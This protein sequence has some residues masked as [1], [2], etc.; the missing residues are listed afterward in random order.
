MIEDHS[1]GP[2]SS[3]H[4]TR[5]RVLFYAF[6]GIGAVAGLLLLLNFEIAYQGKHDWEAY[7]RKALA[8]G[9][10]LD[11]SAFIPPPVPDGQN[12]ACTPS[13][14]PLFDFLPGTQQVR[15][16]NA[17]HFMDRLDA[18]F[19]E[20]A[21][22]RG[23]DPLM[24]DA[25]GWGDYAKAQ[26]YDLV[27]FLGKRGSAL[28][29][30][31]GRMSPEMLKR[32]GLVSNPAPVPAPPA[33]ETPATPTNETEAAEVALGLLK[34]V[35]E[36]LFEELRQAQKRPFCRFNIAYDYDPAYAILLPHVPILRSVCL[37]L[38]A[39]AIAHLVL[40][41]SREAFDDV[42]FTLYLTGT[43]KR[44]PLLVSQLV[45][46]AL[47]Q[48]VYGDIWE[49]IIRHQWSEDELRQL[50]VALEKDRL[51]ADMDWMLQAE[52]A[53]GLHLIEQIRRTGG[54][55]RNDAGEFVGTAWRLFPQGWYDLEKVNYGQTSDALYA[56]FSAWVAGHRT[57][58]QYLQ[59]VKRQEGL[60]VSRNVL[61]RIWEHQ[62]FTGILLPSTSKAAGRAQYCQ[63]RQDQAR[64]ACALER[65]FL[66]HG[67][68]P[69]DLTK[70]APQEISQMPLDV[71]S[72][73]PFKYRREGQRGYCLY[74]VGQNLSD[75]GGQM[76]FQSGQSKRDLNLAEGDWV[77]LI[78][79]PEPKNETPD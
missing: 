43:I 11:Y 49:G 66:A 63:V 55:D 16:T 62:L 58:A 56:P 68:Y 2:G 77:W 40:H 52:R 18:T 19:R 27:R 31:R 76:V 73:A 33:V 61:L 72:G 78:P 26:R 24:K 17:A 67:Q 21:N 71:M 70:L 39:Q 30:G 60:S 53:N 4:S 64:I 29:S 51:V 3:S 15:D 46:L 20:H 25:Q 36:P 28:S 12:F 34:E 7:S 74:S 42:R 57:T 1:H 6:L 9:V 65:F 22:Q 13:L 59:D 10:K 79:N 32:Y 35:Y 8:S 48:L 45:R 50:Q 38:H 23:L 5:N 47:K 54:R 44:E 41:Q 37:K 75:D 69:A 14:A